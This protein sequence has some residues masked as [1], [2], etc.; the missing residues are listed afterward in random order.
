MGS[1]I[2]HLTIDKSDLI[3]A[4]RLADEYQQTIQKASALADELASLDIKLKQS[5]QT[6]KLETLT[7]MMREEQDLAARKQ[8]CDLIMLYQQDLEEHQ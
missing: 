5:D 2:I 6:E 3:K 4:K 8:L 1:N 7:R